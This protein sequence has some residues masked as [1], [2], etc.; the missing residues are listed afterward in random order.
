MQQ[1]VDSSWI[2]GAV[3]LVLR[4]GKVVYQRAVGWSDKEASAPMTT[5]AI[6]RIASQSKALT[7]VAIMMLVEEGKIALTD[8]VSRWLPSFAKTTVANRADTGR[9]VTAAKRQITIFD[10]LTHTAGISY[11]TEGFVAER[12]RAADLGP[13]AGFG[14]YTADKTEPICV[15]MDRLGTLPFISAARRSV[16]VRVQHRHPRLRGGARERASRST[17]S[18]GAASRARSG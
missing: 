14:W 4:D 9:T 16:G 7:S 5:D 12:Y 18:S 10:L 3:A 17:S 13:A 2:A 15:S 1:A 6:F 11:G 8:P